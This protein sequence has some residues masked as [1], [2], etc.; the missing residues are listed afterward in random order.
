MMFFLLHVTLQVYWSLVARSILL[1]ASH[2]MS[3][4]WGTVGRGYGAELCDDNGQQLDLQDTIKA[5]CVR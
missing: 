4:A 5:L 3:C 1:I 2:W